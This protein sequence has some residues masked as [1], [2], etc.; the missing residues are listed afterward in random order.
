MKTWD[1]VT[2]VGVGL[3]GA[4]VGLALRKRGLARN[5]VGVGRNQSKLRRA[6]R[7]GAITVATQDVEHGVSDADVVVICTPVESIG[8]FA[9]RAALACPSGSLVTDT[10]STKSNIV[11]S[12]R[13]SWPREVGF[14]GSHPLAGSEKSGCEHGQAN[15]FEDRVTVVTPTPKT[16]EKHLKKAVQFWN[17][18]G[19]VVIQMSPKQHDQAIA[20]T[21]HLP[22]VVASVLA[23][24]TGKDHLSLAASGWL[25]TT[26]IASGNVDLWRQILRDNQPQ[27]LKAIDKFEKTLHSFRRALQS[28]KRQTVTRILAKGKENRDSLGN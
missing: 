28:G 12:V 1:T 20:M 2:I 4:S 8:P 17:S 24:S 22:H 10:G 26:R 7:Q 16:S 25:D 9:E 14:V 18:L 11:A 6:R 23:A 21:S 3:I 19:S 15:L 5:V 13:P 27:V